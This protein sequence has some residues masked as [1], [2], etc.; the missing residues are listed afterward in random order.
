VVDQVQSEL[1]LQSFLDD[2]DQKAQKAAAK[3]EARATE[4]YGFV[5]KRR[6]V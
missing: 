5:E 2:S 6:V 1:A 3:A 4:F